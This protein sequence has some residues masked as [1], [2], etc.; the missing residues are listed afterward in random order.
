MLLFWRIRY[1]DCRDKQFKNRD[2][3]LN[4]DTLDP[5]TKAAVEA[6]YALDDSGRRA[7]LR[8]RHLFQEERPDENSL[9]FD[10]AFCVSGYF[11]DEASQELSYKRMAVVLT[12]DQQAVFFPP[13]TRQHDAEYC[14]AEKPPIDL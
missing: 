12:G 5:V 14:L 8:F 11:E 6:T 3:W 1:L 10:G 2:L 13:G 7:M 9:A 4:T